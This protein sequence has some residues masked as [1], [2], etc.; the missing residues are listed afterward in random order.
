MDLLMKAATTAALVAGL[1]VVLRRAGPGIGGLTA[2]LPL[3]SAPALYWLTQQQG[4]PLAAQAATAA[5]L[6]TA[7]TPLMVAVY[8]RL[9]LRHGPLRCLGA[10][11]SA[12]ALGIVLLQPLL[13]GNVAGL[14]MLAA[15]FYVLALRLLPQP[16][17]RASRPGA[18][19]SEML[20][21]IALSVL[22]TVLMGAS[23]LTHGA[24][25]C[26]LLAA[27]PVVGASTL[28]SLHRQQGAP[29]ACRFLAGYLDGIA[30][31]AAFFAALAVGL[32]VLPPLAAWVAAAGSSL[33]TLW[34]VRQPSLRRHHP[35]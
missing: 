29:M 27:A 18:W 32:L 16:A 3:T 19:R 6:A 30:A 26:G 21:T 17:Q 22:L 5:L 15:T 28:Y 23:E 35:A 2:A 4:E 25:P 20:L 34:M 11:L 31:R 7:L 12:A 14:L 33:F 10:G 8:G 13:G 24:G 9:S 1:L